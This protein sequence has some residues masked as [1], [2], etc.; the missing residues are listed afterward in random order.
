MA[1]KHSRG[2]WQRGRAGVAAVAIVVAV[3]SLLVTS[4]ATTRATRRS[5][6]PVGFLG[7]YSQ[8]REG[9]RGEA[10][11]LF[12]SPRTDFSRYTSVIIES[13]TL[14]E[15]KGTSD[16]SAGDRQILTDYFYLALLR[17][18]EKDFT[19]VHDPAPGV[20]MVRAAITEARGSKPVVNTITSVVPQLR[21]LTTLGGM[22]S[23]AAVFV[24][25][26]GIE[27]EV[28][29]AVTLERVGAGVDRRAGTKALRSGIK[30]WSDTK[31]ALDYWADK[32]R[33]RLVRL[34]EQDSR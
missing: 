25:E 2:C 6:E 23:D 3:A 8:L 15:G 12:F 5:A 29:D 9:K 14:W 16:I 31:T 28:R 21:L 30:T 20:L 34:R 32:I 7:D 22:A 26:A 24:G 1:S 4:C 19:I 33:H 13:V 18:I 10:Q 27:V 17:E 11:L